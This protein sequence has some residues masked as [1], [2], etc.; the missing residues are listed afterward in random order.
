LGR[1]FGR[2]RSLALDISPLRD[3]VAYRALWIGQLLSQV[4]T[5]MRFVAVP[6]QVFRIT[7]STV[8]VGLIGLVEVVP[9]VIFSV[10][11]GALADSVERKRLVAGVQIGLIVSAGA[12]AVV[13]FVFR[14]PS[15][16]WIYGLTAIGSAFSALERPARTA[17]APSLVTPEQLPAVMA[18]R[19]VVIQVTQ[20]V[21]PALGGIL[22]GVLA[23]HGLA[24]IGVAWVYVIDAATFLFALASLKWVP[25][26]E[27]APEAP[28][29]RHLGGQVESVREGFRFSLRNDLILPIFVVDL[30]AMIFGMPRAVFP[31]LAER[32]FHGGAQTL[33][34][35]YAA[36]AAGAL[37]GALTTGWVPRVRRRGL[38][39]IAAVAVWG[40]AIAG[41]GLAL[42]SLALTMVLL[43]VAG[44]AD[45][46]SAV[47]RGTMLLENTPE[48]LWGRVSALQLMVVT[49][50]PRLGD[51]E[52]GLVAGAIGAPASIVAGGLACIAGT[53]WVGLKWPRF[54]HYDST[55]AALAGSAPDD[56]AEV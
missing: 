30:S 1:R 50:G 2:A 41:A 53:V 25:R 24:R 27:A 37:I 3:S 55:T 8:A 18:L 20:I 42:F 4:G 22:I 16:W 7:G 19:Q 34:L 29:L 47:F 35:L 45:V 28:E 46:V 36:P 31:A 39:I 40:V 48:Q 52:A 15:L 12:L 21:G 9:L 32:S 54:R 23:A 49:S 33:G 56:I 26:M 10:A 43:A 11:G 6:F 17:M 51:V 13:T 5:Q 14:S 38:A 44:A